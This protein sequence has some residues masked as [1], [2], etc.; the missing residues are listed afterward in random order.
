MAL[1]NFR[2]SNLRLEWRILYT[3]LCV[4]RTRRRLDLI[5]SCVRYTRRWETTVTE[6]NA[7][8]YASFSEFH[9]KE[10]TTLPLKP[11]MA[12]VISY[13]ASSQKHLVYLCS[14]WCWVDKGR[15]TDALCRLSFWMMFKCTL[16]CYVSWSNTTAPLQNIHSI[17]L[18]HII[19]PSNQ[20]HHQLAQNASHGR[21][22]S[23]LRLQR[24]QVPAFQQEGSRLLC[25]APVG[26]LRYPEPRQR[27]KDLV[28]DARSEMRWLWCDIAVEEV[29]RFRSVHLV[30][31]I[32]LVSDRMAI[33]M[34]M[35]WLSF[36]VIDLHLSQSH[37]WKISWR[38]S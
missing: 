20:T 23:P 15:K 29:S 3:S 28:H 34:L 38:Y 37:A 35:A 17:P 9:Y 24:L 26:V 2:I 7:P 14:H 33:S 27:R 36:S 18:Y 12:L 30:L 16:W 1:V 32:R 22:H 10:S 31:R 8:E 13:N 4:G 6:S 21:S 25:K 5:Q 19:L 11:S